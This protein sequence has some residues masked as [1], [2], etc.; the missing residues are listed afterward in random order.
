MATWVADAARREAGL[1]AASAKLRAQ[2]LE[3]GKAAAKLSGQLCEATK[4]ASAA[5]EAARE[6]VRGATGD[7]LVALRSGTDTGS[8]GEEEH[9]ADLEEHTVVADKPE[10]T[11]GEALEEEHAANPEEPNKADDP[12]AGTGEKPGEEPGGA[13][14]IDWSLVDSC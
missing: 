4:V 9:A 10:D 8:P 14:L 2:L 3:A 7:C 5:T 11:T 6:P 13:P 1:V 12:E